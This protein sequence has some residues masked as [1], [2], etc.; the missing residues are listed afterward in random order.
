MPRSPV[1][2]PAVSGTLVRPT[3]SAEAG[4]PPCHVSAHTT[5]NATRLR[6]LF[7]ITPPDPWAVIDETFALQD[8]GLL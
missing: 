2:L 1:T 8:E 4:L 7:G 3:T 5:L 6:E